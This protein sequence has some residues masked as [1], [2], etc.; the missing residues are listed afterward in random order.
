MVSPLY[1]HSMPIIMDSLVPNHRKKQL[2]PESTMEPPA[3]RGQQLECFLSSRMMEDLWASKFFQEDSSTGKPQTGLH[4][5]MSK[6]IHLF[7]RQSTC[8][9]NTASTNAQD[10][11]LIYLTGRIYISYM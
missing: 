1:K 8:P 5:T 7:E 4:R 11:L 6:C 9:M 3:N 2:I 10:P